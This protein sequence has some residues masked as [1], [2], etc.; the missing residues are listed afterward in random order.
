MRRPVPPAAREA[1]VLK[2][3]K[4]PADGRLRQ[5][6]DVAQLINTQLVPLQKRS[7]LSRVGSA[8]DPIHPSKACGAA[9][10]SLFIR[11]SG[12][13]VISPWSCVKRLFEN[14]G[15]LGCPPAVR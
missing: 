3:L 10:K 12:Y 13:N 8:S 4:V 6:K 9:V 7:N 2:H 14:Y 11:I 15:N 1:F 5:L